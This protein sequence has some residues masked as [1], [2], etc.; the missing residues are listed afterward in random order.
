FCILALAGF[1]FVIAYQ[2]IDASQMLVRMMIV[3]I[4]EAGL[5]SCSLCICGRRIADC[6]GL[7]W[8][9]RFLCC[10]RCNMGGRTASGCRAGVRGQ[11]SVDATARFREEGNMKLQKLLIGIALA[12]LILL[13]APVP[14]F[15]QGCALCYTQAA[16]AG[17]RM[18]Q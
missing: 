12:G 14:A 10:L 9:L 18:I 5:R 15:S 11:S 6:Y 17:A 16:S 13:L 2:N 1:Q 4:V 7:W 8:S 3:V